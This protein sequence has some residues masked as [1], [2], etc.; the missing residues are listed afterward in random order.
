MAATSILSTDSTAA[1]SSDITL[2]GDT[3]VSLK[4]ATDGARVVILSKDDGGGYNKVSSLT[5][6]QPAG[7]LPAGVYRFDRIAGATCGVYYNA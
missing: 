2:T 3:L 4:G 5:Q 1:S 7:I 6:Q